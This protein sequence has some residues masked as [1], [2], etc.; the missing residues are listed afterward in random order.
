MQTIRDFAVLQI[1]EMVVDFVEYLDRISVDVI[2]R[3]SQ[4]GVQAGLDDGIPYFFGNECGTLGALRRRAGVFAQDP[5]EFGGGIVQP[6]LP[7]RRG[8]GGGGGR[9]GQ[10][11]VI[12]CCV[13]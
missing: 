3:Q 7:H 13:E 8:G 2:D 9:R 11:L 4:I 5:V 6:G 10:G 1:E 12:D